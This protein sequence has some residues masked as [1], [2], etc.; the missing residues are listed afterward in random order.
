MQTNT[1]NNTAGNNKITNNDQ[2][3]SYTYNSRNKKAA[4]DTLDNG[5]KHVSKKK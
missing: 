5:P 3:N 2:N 4:E 1:K